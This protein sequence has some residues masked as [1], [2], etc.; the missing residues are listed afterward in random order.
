MYSCELAAFNYYHFP[1]KLRH[2]YFKIQM[3]QLHFQIKHK[4]LND[5]YN[6]EHSKN[7]KKIF[8]F[9]LK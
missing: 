9:G 5:N 8:P 7:E 1:T 4:T 2:F 3:E 6:K